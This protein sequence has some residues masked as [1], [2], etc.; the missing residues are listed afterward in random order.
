MHAL[1]NK[2]HFFSPCRHASHELFGI[3]L[4]ILRNDEI[5]GWRRGGHQWE[6]VGRSRD[7]RQNGRHDDSSFGL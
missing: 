7:L 4:N 3:L 1:Q 2:Y 5:V 6:G